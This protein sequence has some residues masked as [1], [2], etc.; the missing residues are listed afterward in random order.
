LYT[1]RRLRAVVL[2][3]G[4]GG[5]Q[6]GGRLVG[7][8]IR[9]GAPALGGVGRGAP[10]HPL[11]LGGERGEAIKLRGGAGGQKGPK[12]ITGSNLWRGRRNLLLSRLLGGRRETVEIR[13]EMGGKEEA[14]RR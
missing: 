14:L 10:D 11:L 12:R 3:G 2:G 13:G 4:R 7:N 6:A 5:A 1:R 9:P 8:L